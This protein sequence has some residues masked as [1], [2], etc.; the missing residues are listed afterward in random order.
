MMESK[1]EN[2]VYWR[3]PYYC[4]FLAFVLAIMI[5]I[6][7]IG[8]QYA[9]LQELSLDATMSA[10]V[11]TQFATDGTVLYGMTAYGGFY[12]RGVIF[13][14]NKDGTSF[15]KLLDFD[16]VAKGA[17]PKGSLTLSGSTIYGMTSAGGTNNYG[18]IF[19]IS[20]DGSGFQKLLDFDGTAKG[21]GPN[22]SLTISGSI[23]YGTTYSGG[24]NNYGVI[25]KINTDGTGFQKLLD[26]GVSVLAAYPNGS[27]V[28][29]GSVLYG[30]TV[31][32]G[33]NAKGVI[34]KINTDGSGFTR[35]FSFDGT[36]SGANPYGSLTISGTKLYGMTTYGG[37]NNLG[38]IFRINTNGTNYTKLLD[39][40]GTNNGASPTGSLFLSGTVLYGATS[41]GGINGNGCVFSINTD[42]TNFWKKWNLGAPSWGGYD[43]DGI[44]PYGSVI[45]IGN[46][47]IGMTY[48]G[49]NRDAGTIF[50][51]YDYSIGSSD[52]VYRKLRDCYPAYQGD[53]LIGDFVTDGT[54][55]YGTAGDG[56][57]NNKGAI[58]KINTD[59]TGFQDI[60]HFNTDL[61]G[62]TPVSVILSG[63]T[64]YGMTHDG[65]TNNAGTIFK[66]SVD[67]TGFQKIFD[68]AL[69]TTGNTP[70]GK[71]T[72]I[73]SAL[74]GTTASG[75]S[76]NKGTVF[77]INTDGTGYQTLVDFDGTSKGSY[78]V[79]SLTL[80]GSTFYGT[81]LRG[82]INDLG[83]IFKINIDGTGFQK[84][85]DFDGTSKGAN[86]S[87]G[88]MIPAGTALYGMT[89]YGGSNNVGVLFKINT[90][91]SGFQKLLDFD[92]TNK[93]ARPAYTSLTYFN[94]TLYGT[95]RLGGTNNYG[96]IFKINPDGSN[97][98]KIFDFNS[99]SGTKPSNSLL[100]VNSALYGTTFEGGS[101]GIGVIYK[102]DLTDLQIDAI[103]GK[104]TCAV[105]QI[106]LNVIS[107]ISGVTY[108]WSGPNGFSSTLQNPEISTPGN[109]I[110][111]VTYSGQS[112]IDTAIVTQDITTPVA[113]AAGATIT[114]TNTSV[115]LSGS[116]VTSGVT[117]SWDGPNG[118]TSPL[119]NPT[120]SNT[121]TYT[122]TVTN[123]VNGC[124]STASAIV[125]QN[126]TV[127]GAS[128]G[129]SGILTCN[130]TSV[131]L[132][133][134]SPTSG[135][136]Y[137]WSG[138]LTFAST[139]Q[140]PIT[141]NPG[142]YILVVTN[143]ANG[144][145]SSGSI[146]VSHDTTTAT[147]VSASV[148][149]MLTCSV[150][151]V[152]MEAISSSTGVT[153]GWTGPNGFHSSSQNIVVSTSGNY[154]LQVSK[155]SNGC[156]IAVNVPVL[157]DTLKPQGVAAEASGILSCSASSVTLTG[158]STTSGVSYNWVGPN[159]VST[160]A[161]TI[162]TNPGSYTLTV[163][164]PANG[165]SVIKQ[166]F[167]GQNATS[168]ANVS[169]SVSG[170][171]NCINAFVTLSGASTTA[172]AEYLWI[173]PDQTEYPNSITFAFE[174]GIYKLLVTDPGNGC[175]DS[176]SIAV[177]CD[178]ISPISQII[179][180]SG[181]P[182]A[183]TTNTIS[184]QTVA[185]TSY[186]WGISSSNTNWI[187]ISGA[188]NQALTYQSGDAGSN[189]IFALTVTG[190]Q[191][192]CSSTSQVTLTSVSAL[193]KLP[194]AT[195]GV[196]EQDTVF[197][198]NAYPNP[199]TDKAVIDFTPTRDSHIEIKLY[200]ASGEMMQ[201][202]FDDNVQA[203]QLYQAIVDNKRLH[204]G[205]YYYIIHVNSQAYVQKLIF[206]Q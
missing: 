201:L 150:T 56:G 129:V 179:S 77:K 151:S 204:A 27:L 127:P 16:G 10:P 160:E 103:G 6:P 94:S 59:G 76:V 102:Y 175:K 198:Y 135:V 7:K 109:Y 183:L 147:G 11:Y 78:P 178:T 3:L 88:S 38:C 167:V 138:P 115:I 87:G 182:I 72:L 95:T 155:P 114:C 67:G 65:G 168:P 84:L 189:A 169:A 152:T 117:Y 159:F 162:V 37:V 54:I 132:L 199:F 106:N 66:I 45:L 176:V 101:S 35:L 34:F 158:S 188:N 142:T 202:L 31:Y 33:S 148:S 139:E 118:F 44:N 86:P 171:I 62:Y 107:N 13:K 55:I 124:A 17:Y 63:T 187:I 49:G 29:S 73:G 121:G 47:I 196:G 137:S 105:P 97:F 18:V 15:Q 205:T 41:Y 197:Q 206:I 81:T 60:Y 140:N 53:Y 174:P 191:N 26:L 100:L 143:P 126:N 104:L 85:L 111:T 190:N 92:G 130:A 180:P 200:S 42:G 57:T 79:G 83:V 51:I 22:G 8:A 116:S 119:Q 110:V 194:I 21:A 93:G 19:K 99:T 173:S 2:S 69:S 52:G 128:A 136:T 30:M 131:S 64:L 134:S 46:E 71:L 165:C 193:K 74:Y 184:A 96:V 154:V 61:N 48:K 153:Y 156:A 123:P 24:A 120:V 146:I 9:N 203:H 186:S 170:T 164:N 112:K 144:C 50:R 75:G 68:F 133:G 181:S 125:D 4:K 70:Y 157:Q 177:L 185:N 90:D 32:A 14:V 28:I 91:G 40:D 1:K 166:V 58:F 12:G 36:N 145:T 122:L 89:E 172:N 192:G 141:A 43:N 98:E 20:T 149:G 25:F 108:A 195:T 5:Q 80:V 163:G 39:F 161:V 113:T 23:L 82:G